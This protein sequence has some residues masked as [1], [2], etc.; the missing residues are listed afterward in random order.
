[1]PLSVYLE[2][3]M[4]QTVYVTSM[5]LL[6]AGLSSI[7]WNPISN[8]YGRRPVYIITVL[9][10]LLMSVASGQ[11]TSYGPL[12]AY[13]CLNGFFG[14]VPAGLG[15]AI[16]SDL[17]FTHERG[18]YMGIYTVIFITGGHIAPIIG[19]YIAVNL[20]WEWCFYIPA[21]ITAI[22]WLA[23]VLTVPET[24]YLRSP[25][26]PQR[27]W[28]QNMTLQG[29]ANSARKLHLIDFV[30]PFQM[31]IYPSVLL[32]TLY[33]AVAFSYG[34]VLFIISSASL[35][36]MNYQFGPTETG[37]LLGIPITVGSLLGELISGGFSDWISER[38]AIT[39]GRRRPEDRLLAIIPSFFITP[40]G[41]IV[42]GVCLANNTHYMGTAMG[43][44]LASFGLQIATTVVYTYTSE[45]YKPQS[46]ELG[47]IINFSR[48]ILSFAMSFYALPFSAVIGVQDAWIVLAF[49]IVVFFIPLIPLYF[50]GAKWRDEIGYPSFNSD[51]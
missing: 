1:M 49:L 4:D 28:M 29:R 47:S 32:P 22:A 11:A 35:F 26:Q 21:I 12:L 42:E 27:T 39:R 15:N 14:G 45:C 25:G 16:V 44:A 36:A 23:F 43:I 20:S 19:G 30:R 6:A 17:F 40:L 3:E 50:W 46:P 33:Y 37:L 51:L 13:R 48:Q 38:R 34:S 2:Y 5:F 8:V 41:I 10:G 31:L 9:V 7:F 24:L 18:L